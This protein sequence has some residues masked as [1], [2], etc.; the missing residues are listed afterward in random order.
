MSLCKQLVLAALVL[1]L[2]LTA[3]AS[4]VDFGNVGGT[5]TA[6]NGGTALSLSGSTLTSVSGFGGG[7]I[8][9]NNLGSVTFTTGTLS[10]G[11]LAGGGTFAPGGSFVIN[12][13]GSNG[14]PNGILFS[15]TFTSGTWAAVPVGSKT[16]F[17]F[18]GVISGGF[19]SG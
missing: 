14:L 6:I 10:S 2:P 9:G 16:S 7:L 8:T 11:S 3:F 1:C 19:A 4:S 18:T 15:G 17:T 5:V 13:Y 12:T